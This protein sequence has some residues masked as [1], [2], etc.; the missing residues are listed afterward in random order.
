MLTEAEILAGLKDIL[1]RIA[2][3]DPAGIELDALII[4][5]VGVDSLGFYEILIEADETM[6]IKI[7]E[8]DLLTF[9]TVRDIVDYVNAR[10]FT[11][12]QPAP[13]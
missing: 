12:T 3:V 13:R 2:G 6:G 4:D 11:A 10:A 9:K 8:K 5:D 7:E 1:A